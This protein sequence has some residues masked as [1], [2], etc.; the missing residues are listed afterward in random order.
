[1]I[2]D[3]LWTTVKHKGAKSQECVPR[4]MMAHVNHLEDIDLEEDFEDLDIEE[5]S[6]EWDRTTSSPI[7]WERT[8]SSQ[9]FRTGF[10]QRFLDL[11]TIYVV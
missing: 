5:A 3:F 4:V 9:I 1:M 6:D 8:G 2:H 7:S 10:S 11:V